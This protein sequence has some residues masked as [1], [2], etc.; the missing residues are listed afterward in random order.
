MKNNNPNNININ[1]YISQISNDDLLL[2]VEDY[3]YW[4]KTGERKFDHTELDVIYDMY[5]AW[6]EENRMFGTYDVITIE[7]SKRLFNK[8]I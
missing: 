5:F 2:C 8:Q 6:L 1:D 4:Q 3:L 7:K